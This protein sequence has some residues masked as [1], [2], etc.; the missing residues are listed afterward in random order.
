MLNQCL[1]DFIYKQL[2]A[3][4]LMSTRI[5]VNNANQNEYMCAETIFQNYKLHILN[6]L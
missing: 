5:F 1:L 3:V 4:L 6:K 2:E